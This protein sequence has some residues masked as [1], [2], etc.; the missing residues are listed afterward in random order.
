MKMNNTKGRS[1]NYPS[2]GA[3]DPDVGER[4][5]S[6]YVQF[7]V[8]AAAFFTLVCMTIVLYRRWCAGGPIHLHTTSQNR[9][10]S[11][12]SRRDS[13][14]SIVDEHIYLAPRS[15]TAVSVSIKPPPYCDRPPPY[16]E[17]VVSNNMAD[18]HSVRE[19]SRR[20]RITDATNNIPA[21]FILQ[22]EA[23]IVHL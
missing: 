1:G 7:I 16:E 4:E 21:L 15:S 9:R 6:Y 3:S 17:L 19:P 2:Y 18:Q 11:S 10:T 13:C 22:N 20:D 14:Q 5:I 8:M 23:A 12:A